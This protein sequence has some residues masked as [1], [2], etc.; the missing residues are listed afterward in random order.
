[1]VHKPSLSRDMVEV[2]NQL[3]KSGRKIDRIME[4]P[5]KKGN[6]LLQKSQEFMEAHG[7]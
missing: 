4:E 5:L 1:V 3:A 2:R 6:K 7:Y